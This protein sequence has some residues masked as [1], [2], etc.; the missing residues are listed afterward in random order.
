MKSAWILLTALLVSQ[1]YAQ[2]PKSN[3][4]VSVSWLA[5][6]IKDPQLVL[7]H[8]GARDGF[9]KEH[10]AGA[11]FVSL[12]DISEP[13]DASSTA[14]ILE[15]PTATRFQEAMETRGVSNDSRIVVYCASNNVSTATRVI[16][17]LTYF[18]M[19]DRVS[20]LD[21]GMAAWRA[22]GH[23]LT[24]E[25][26]PAK[27]GHFAPNV[28][29]EIFADAKWI[30]EHLHKTGVSVVDSR[31]ADDYAGEQ[32]SRAMP[33]RGHIPGAASLPIE[34]FM[35][36]NGKLLESPTL[37]GL[38]R[39]AAV[40]PGTEVVSYCYIGQRATLTWFVARLLGYNAR[41]YDGSWDEWS[42]R[43]ELPID[44]GATKN[45]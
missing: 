43:T 32:T 45:Q 42:K 17:T 14:L 23:A 13:R 18:G 44:T 19:G 37:A 1:L 34:K 24:A 31:L 4:L 11:Q 30:T 3:L 26:A 5:D 16:W 38:L 9:D 39:E 27:R 36:D 29:P 40:K 2:S 33:R 22:T 41:M 28:H 20:L 10:I 25:T 35:D 6:H 7:L 8:V 12:Q 15:L 21:G